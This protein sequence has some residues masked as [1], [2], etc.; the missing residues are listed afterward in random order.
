M[1]RAIQK[2]QD[3]YK[4]KAS[5]REIEVPEWDLKIYVAPATLETMHQ[6]IGNG[7]KTSAEIIA[8]TLI[9]RARDAEGN[10]LFT[11]AEVDMLMARS[12]LPTITRVAARI[13]NDLDFDAPEDS[14]PGEGFAGTPQSS[15][16]SS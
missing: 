5:I 8:Q 12:W 1:A 4:K 13:N 7:E 9:H 2:I 11:R 10:P 16:S 3:E 14:S 15:T 6:I